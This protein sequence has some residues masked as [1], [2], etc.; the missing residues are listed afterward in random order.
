[1]TGDPYRT[2]MSAAI[3][4]YGRPG[5]STTSAS[6]RSPYQPYLQPRLGGRGA[7]VGGRG[8]RRSPYPVMGTPLMTPVSAAPTPSPYWGG[9]PDP[10]LWNPGGDAAAPVIPPAAGGAGGGPLIPSPWATPWPGGDSGGR[11]DATSAYR[12]AVLSAI[13]RWLRENMGGGRIAV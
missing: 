3:R 1:M 11:T 13:G 5:A 8:I 7:G 12:D 4:G 6:I 9:G 2:A 10:E